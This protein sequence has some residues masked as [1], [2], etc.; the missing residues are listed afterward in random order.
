[1]YAFRNLTEEEC[2]WFASFG[3]SEVD[4]IR[5]VNGQ[6]FVCISKSLTK[7]LQI[8][9]QFA[10]SKKG[11]QYYYEIDYTWDGKFMFGGRICTIQE[12]NQEILKEENE[13]I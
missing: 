12:T 5:D 2:D 4:D 13:D 7:P 11:Y 8:V 1:M 9:L 10:L 6:S 3:K